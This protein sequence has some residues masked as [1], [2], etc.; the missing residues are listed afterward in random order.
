MEY[1]EAAPMPANRPFIKKY[2]AVKDVSSVGET[3]PEPILPDGCVEIVFDLSD[4][5][6]QYHDDGTSELQPRTIVAGQMSRR[7]FIGP[8]GKTDLFGVR[9]HPAGSWPLLRVS[10]DEITDRIIDASM[11]LGR[12]EDRLFDMLSEQTGFAERAAIF[13]SYF[14]SRLAERGSAF[15]AVARA[16]A[17]IAASDSSMSVD[18]IARQIGLSERSL[19]RNFRRFVGLPPKLFIRITRFQNF[20]R[21]VEAHSRTDLL[22]IAVGSG[23][24]DQSHMI[25]DF[26]AFTGATPSEFF[27]I[28]KVLSDRFVNGE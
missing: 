6:R 23:Y 15:D 7:I 28:E 13:D 26:R 24:Y 4:R 25:R 18:V 9:F 20:I 17:I 22:D 21:T 19:E 3:A 1:R 12:D 14:Y 10:L 5:F 16:S 27:G 11:L 8:T 2:W